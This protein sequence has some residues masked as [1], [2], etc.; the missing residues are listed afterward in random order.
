MATLPGRCVNEMFCSVAAARDVVSVPAEGRFVCPSCGRPLVAPTGRMTTRAQRRGQPR[1]P[2]L[3]LLACGFAAGTVIGALFVEPWRPV[4]KPAASAALDAP[5][6][7][8]SPPG[9]RQATQAQPA[10][11]TAASII[12][13]A[14]PVTN[15]VPGRHRRRSHATVRTSTE[16]QA[17]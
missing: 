13:T 2:G 4:D 16:T 9:Q 12:P 1:A 11:I 5:A 10:P 3:V 17:N 14:A 8:P 15:T 6:P 7:Q